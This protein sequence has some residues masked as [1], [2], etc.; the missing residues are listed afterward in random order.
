MYK[1]VFDLSKGGIIK[2]LIAKKEGNKEFAKNNG[3]YSLGE[4]RGYFYEEGKFHSSTETPARMTILSN[5]EYETRI[6]VEG[7]IATHPFTQVITLV[8]GQKRID[9]DLTV[10][11]KNNVGIGEYEEKNCVIIAELIVMIGLN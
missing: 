4:M 2:S 1:I 7:E 8:R 6:Q 10:N 3:E 5:N 9:F 11:W